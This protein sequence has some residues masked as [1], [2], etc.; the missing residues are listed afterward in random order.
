[1]IYLDSAA[2]TKP[3]DAAVSAA[4]AAMERDWGNPSSL[5][6]LGLD[7]EDIISS[8]RETA[9]SLLGC[10]SREVYF[11]AGGTEAN[12]IAVLGAARA[13]AG[14]GRRVVT[15]STEHDSV[16]KCGLRLESEGFE[17]VR[18]DPEPDGS[19]SAGKVVSA[20]T[21]DTC[22]VSIALVNN[23]TGAW[24]PV[25][26]VSRYI[27]SRGLA[28]LLHTDAVQAFGKIPFRVGELGVDLLSASAHKIHGLKGT[29]LLYKRAG[30]TLE[31]VIFGGEQ[32]GGVAPGTENVPGI[33]AFGAA[34]REVSPVARS[35][36][37]P[38]YNYLRREV[39]EAGY[40]V[41]TPEDSSGF[42]LNFSVPGYRSETLLHYLEQYGVYLSSGSACGRGK[43]SRVLRAA[44]LP[45]EAVD[46]A[47]RVSLSP[48]NTLDELDYLLRLLRKARAELVGSA[49]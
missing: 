8:A 37:L 39:I 21:G 27:K 10:E 35:R 29:G 1:M 32:E 3:C 42:V 34:M 40:T 6:K 26:E 12:N 7:A 43:P 13:H 49:K 45:R 48:E 2:T 11:T 19:V 23:E 5:Y 25:R 38:L 20:V 41:N 36:V 47:L 17:V 33:A 22:L 9:A 14:A 15:L 18:V 30:V 24:G 31:P 4:R 16:H 44:G 28:A 46:S